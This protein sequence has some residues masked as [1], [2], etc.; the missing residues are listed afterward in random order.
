MSASDNVNFGLSEVDRIPV[1]G[2]SLPVA[3]RRGNW[4]WPN[5][6]LAF[7][8]HLIA[9]RARNKALVVDLRPPR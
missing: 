6:I 7:R 9:K 5:R 3:K 4:R 8:G 2:L 1:D